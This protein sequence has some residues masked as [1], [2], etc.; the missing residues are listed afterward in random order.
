M[1]I[2]DRLYERA[3][4][5]LYMGITQNP[6]DPMIVEISAYA[7]LVSSS[8]VDRVRINPN[9]ILILDDVDRYYTTNIV[10]VETDE[11]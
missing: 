4:K 2:C 9:N 3:R 10:S 11:K 1:F 5:F 6:D 7:P 8:I